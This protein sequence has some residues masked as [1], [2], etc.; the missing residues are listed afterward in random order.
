MSLFLPSGLPSRPP[1]PLHLAR[2]PQWLP[3]LAKLGVV[4]RKL[5]RTGRRQTSVPGPLARQRPPGQTSEAP[6][7]ENARVNQSPGRNSKLEGNG[8]KDCAGRA[9]VHRLLQVAGQGTPRTPPEAPFPRP[10]REFWRVA[11]VHSPG[12]PGRLWEVLASFVAV[13]PDKRAPLA[14]GR[15]SPTRRAS[16]PGCPGVLSAGSLGSH[17][18]IPRTALPEH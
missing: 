8:T 18:K 15:A 1:L 17:F 7:E 10:V 3:S 4:A 5:F 9:R 13:L 12:D 2:Q 16:R 14:R 11:A 6:E